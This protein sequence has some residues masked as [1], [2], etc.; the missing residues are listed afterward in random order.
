M[1]RLNL[2]FVC[3]TLTF[4]AACS[5]ATPTTLTTSQIESVRVVKPND[6]NYIPLNPSRG[7][8]SPQAGVLWGDIRQ[9]VASGVLLKFA[10]GF[11]SPP[12]I[13]NITYRAVVIAGDM[14]ND[15]PDAEKLWMGPGSFWTQPAG[16]NHI[17]A[18]KPG[19]GATAFL[20]ILTGPYLVQPALEAFETGERPIN[21]LSS[22][23][24]WMG[25]NDFEW[26]RTASSTGIGPEVALL[27]GDLDMGMPSG[28]LVRLP[29]SYA[30]NI[31][32]TGGML[33]SVVIQGQ[34]SHTVTTVS[35]TTTIGP[36]GFFE[37]E[38]GVPHS[39]ACQKGKAC[40]LYVRTDGVFDVR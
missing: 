8:R 20:E 36:G 31:S 9:D 10:D 4:F 15:D 25:A 14:H 29:S 37:S 21:L 32:S 17:T 39:L 34:L 38:E 26:I 23:L 40:V 24:V 27:W 19:S 16:E 33:R 30:G 7:D 35:D 1:K 2:I 22:N 5:K 12:H 6:V 13:H 11:S 28:S 3:I 18:A